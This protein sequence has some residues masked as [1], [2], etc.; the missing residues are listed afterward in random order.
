MKNIT[1]VMISLMLI[2]CLNI[3]NP[4]YANTSIE[5]AKINIELYG[6]VTTAS[7]G[8]LESEQ[9]KYVKLGTISS[10]NLSQTGDQSAPIPFQFEMRNCPPDGSV[11]I[12]FDG[13]KDTDNIELLAL[14][15]VT[16]KASNIA[17]EIRDQDKNRLA[18]GQ[19]ST[20][21]KVDADGHASALFYANYIVTKGQA[22]AGSANANAQF[23]IQYD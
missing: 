18:I 15:N 10:K 6:V 1:K 20:R 2:N 16:N 21:F 9:E 13:V 22:T 3:S 23:S 7:C 5:L 17:I 14:E 11:T 19:Q 4:A 12:R 8:V